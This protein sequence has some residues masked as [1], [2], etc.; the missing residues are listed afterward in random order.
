[1]LDIRCSLTKTSHRF[2]DRAISLFWWLWQQALTTSGME[3]GPDQKGRHFPAIRAKDLIVVTIYVPA[4]GLKDLYLGVSERW[5]A[6]FMKTGTIV[7]MGTLTVA[8]RRVLCQIAGRGLAVHAHVWE[9]IT[10]KASWIVCLLHLRRGGGSSSSKNSHGK[11]CAAKCSWTGYSQSSGSKVARW[12][13]AICKVWG[14]RSHVCPPS[15]GSR[16]GPT[17]RGSRIAKLRFPSA[18]HAATEQFRLLPETNWFM[19]VVTA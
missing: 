14:H 9:G 16:S 18:Y 8:D 5:L 7:F 3:R 12:T 1:M 13:M 6:V 19:T 2:R 11:P 4:S 15:L 10:Q 17:S